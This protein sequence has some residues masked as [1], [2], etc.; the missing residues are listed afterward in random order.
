MSFGGWGFLTG[1]DMWMRH[2]WR[3]YV[4]LFLDGLAR[5]FWGMY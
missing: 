1:C 5:S 3:A 4:C 2:G